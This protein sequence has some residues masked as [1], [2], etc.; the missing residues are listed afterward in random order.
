MNDNVI[1]PDDSSSK[2]CTCDTYGCALGN[3]SIELT[4]ENP[5]AERWSPWPTAR[6]WSA[7]PGYVPSP[8]TS[9]QRRWREVLLLMD[10]A[11]MSLPSLGQMGRRRRYQQWRGR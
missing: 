2:A 11:Y 6:S 3:A 4:E 1:Q 9:S 10:G 8:A 7:S 5:P